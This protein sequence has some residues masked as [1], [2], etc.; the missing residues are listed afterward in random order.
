MKIAKLNGIAGN[1]HVALKYI[2][3]KTGYQLLQQYKQ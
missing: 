3:E 2:Y 1:H